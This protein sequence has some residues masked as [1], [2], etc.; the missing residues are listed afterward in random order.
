MGNILHEANTNP[1]NE[2]TDEDMERFLSMA[3]EPAAPAAATKAAVPAQPYA[4]VTAYP[5]IP[6]A[7]H[8]KPAAAQQA[9][10][11]EEEDMIAAYA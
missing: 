4:P 3:D 5:S 2:V 10:S 9:M 11:K 7:Q 8:A 1:A 6:T